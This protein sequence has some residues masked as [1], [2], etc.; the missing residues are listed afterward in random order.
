MKKFNNILIILISIISLILMGYFLINGIYD[1]IISSASIL[2]VLCLPKILGKIFKIEIGMKGELIYIIFIFIVQ[3]LGSTLSFY[4]MFWWYD[5]LAH[6]A[7]GILTSLLALEV[8][9]WFKVY[10]RENIWFNV[11]FINSF[12][13]M[14][15]ALWEFI[16]FGT[17][18]FLNMDVQHHLTTGVFDTME[19]MLMAFLGCIFVSIWYLI[20]M[21]KIKSK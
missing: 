3:F 13:L 21:K 1:R 20:R 19:D 18:I 11:L 5:I 4:D 10:K 7:S 8:M 14:I 15:A 6:F 17:F 2:L 12:T 9:S 16:E